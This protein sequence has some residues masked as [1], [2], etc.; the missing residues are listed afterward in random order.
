MDFK[1]NI[2]QQTIIRS[3]MYKIEITKLK[4]SNVTFNKKSKDRFKSE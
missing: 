2:I 4:S 1:I 3:R